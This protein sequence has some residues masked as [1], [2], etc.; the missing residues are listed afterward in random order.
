MCNILYDPSD[1]YIQDRKMTVV[2]MLNKDFLTV[3]TTN[4][5]FETK[6]I[7][8][9]LMRI[10]NYSLTVLNNNNI[11]EWLKNEFVYYTL[12]NF[13][14]NSIPLN[15]MLF[16]P[17][18]GKY[19]SDIPRDVQRRIEESTITIRTISCKKNVEFTNELKEYFS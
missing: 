12:Y 14:N 16:F 17:Y 6:V 5:H 15:N 1:F 19:F 7:E 18:K 9:C 2:E 4:Q 10:P 11:Y 8:D 13:I 3:P